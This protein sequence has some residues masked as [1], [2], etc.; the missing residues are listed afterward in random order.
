MSDLRMTAAC[1]DC[2]FWVSGTAA[3]EHAGEH[4]DI[5][6]EHRVSVTR[7]G[8]VRSINEDVSP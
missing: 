7:S 2:V 1:Q 5:Y 3:L 6:P 4:I 8:R